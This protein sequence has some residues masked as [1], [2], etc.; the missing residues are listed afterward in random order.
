MIRRVLA[1]RGHMR[2]IMDMAPRSDYAR[3]CHE[4]VL[5]AHGALC[6]SPELELSLSTSCPLEIVDGR[7]VRAVIELRAREPATFVLDRVEPGKTPMP[8]SAA[9]IAAEFG[10]TAEFW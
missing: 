1:V 9:E 7:D 6:R 8:Y 2:F 3:S 10:A 5:S 4:V